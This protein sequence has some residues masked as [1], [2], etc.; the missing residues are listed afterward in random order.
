VTDSVP[1]AP[2]GHIFFSG[3]DRLEGILEW[4]AGPDG[5]VGAGE[6]PG[7]APEVAPPVAGGVVVAHPHP[8]YGGTMAQPVVYRVAQAS[9][10][11]GFASLRFNFRGV[12]RSGGRYSGVEEHRDVEAAL[13]YLR[14]RIE[15]GEPRRRPLGL[16][17]YS[18]G[19][20]M[21]A[22]AAGSGQ[23]PVDALALIALVVDWAGSPPGALAG[24][25]GFR[26]PVLAVCAELDEL[27]PPT[28]VERALRDLGVDFRLTVIDGAGHMFERRQR[29]VGERVADF[30]AEKLRPGRPESYGGRRG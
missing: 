19:S 27:A 23:V 9:R 18:F 30:F 13:A 15:T 3:D 20:M 24:L 11:R 4:P 12:E 6:Q 17:G 7:P 29:E 8:L 10:E 2:R 5:G 26:G 1:P 25:A 14:G 16:A 21:A 28:V 22:M